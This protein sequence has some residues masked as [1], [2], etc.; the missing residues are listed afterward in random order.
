[1]IGRN[2]PTTSSKLEKKSNL[3]VFETFFADDSEF[4]DN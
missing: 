1:M 3:I 4:N 2:K